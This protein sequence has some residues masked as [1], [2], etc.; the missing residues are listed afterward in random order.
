ME[1]LKKRQP[2][3]QKKDK[4]RSI[5]YRLPVNIVDELETEAM[6]K[7]IARTIE[8]EPDRVNVKA[9]TAEGLGIIGKGEGMAAMCVALLSK[10]LA[11]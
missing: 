11:D 1:N 8:I 7:N 9:T 6:Q 3:L 2:H 5:T 4:T 10:G